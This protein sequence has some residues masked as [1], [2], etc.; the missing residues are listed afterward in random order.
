M[1]RAG[2]R[3]GGGVVVGGGGR[4]A[5]EGWAGRAGRRGHG[6]GQAS[7]RGRTDV[8]GRE[9]RVAHGAHL[10]RVSPEAH[11]SDRDEG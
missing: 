11:T 2:R 8:H 4:E 9:L 1:W 7:W 3:G 10:T 6:R 5:G